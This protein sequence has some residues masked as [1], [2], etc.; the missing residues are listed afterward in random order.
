MLEEIVYGLPPL[1]DDLEPS[2]PC[3][4]SLFHQR[5]PNTLRHHRRCT[6]SGASPVAEW[7]SLPSLAPA[8][9]SEAILAPPV[10]LLAAAGFARGLLQTASGRSRLPV[11]STRR[12]HGVGPATR[13]RLAFPKSALDRKATPTGSHICVASKKIVEASLEVSRPVPV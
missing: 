8:R 7:G 4:L 11:P 13:R 3:F 6:A 10:G 12:A 2:V 9:P 5:P 1:N